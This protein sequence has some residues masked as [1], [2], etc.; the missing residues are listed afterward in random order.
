MMTTET[1][2]PSVLMRAAFAALAAGAV[3]VAVGALVSG[4]PAAWG[5]V[6]G[7]LIAV[8]VFAFGA[9]TVDAV[10]RLM[11][12]ASLLFALLTYTFQVAAMALAF[13]VVS[14]AGLLDD[15]LSRNWLGGAIIV[16]AFVW[17]AAQ[18]RL[19]T[20]ARIPAFQ[21]PSEGGAR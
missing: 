4:S 14:S 10:A 17:M 8:G 9:F 15:E 12:A 21:T 7:T 16:G 1:R 13:V 5:A 11:P 2:A 3:L 6:V 18:I 19:A 20:T